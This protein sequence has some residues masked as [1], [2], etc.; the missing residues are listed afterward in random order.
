MINS[1]CNY[2]SLLIVNI[3]YQTSLT[4]YNYITCNVQ[5]MNTKCT[6]RII[7]YPVYIAHVSYYID[8]NN[9]YNCVDLWTFLRISEIYFESVLIACDVT[10]V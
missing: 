7:S 9:Y 4:L 1:T 8:Y 10:S 6:N 3:Y 5:C 2:G